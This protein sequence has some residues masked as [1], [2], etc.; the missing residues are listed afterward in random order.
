LNGDMIAEGTFDA[1]DAPMT[2]SLPLDRLNLGAVNVLEFLRSGRL[3]GRMYY[4]AN[5]RYQT[6]APT[7]KR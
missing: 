7:R 2:M 5:L 4:T 6:P 3:F 1:G